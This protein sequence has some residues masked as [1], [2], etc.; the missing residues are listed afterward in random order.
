MA[1]S[2]TDFRGAFNGVRPNRFS[3]SGSFPQD[4]QSSIPFTRFDVYCKATQLPGSSIG[5]I[6]VPWMGRVTKFSGERTY[7]DW[8]IQVYDSSSSS[9]DLRSAFE[10]WIEY[11][12]GRDNHIIRY[13]QTAI[14]KVFF[15]DITNAVS[16]QGNPDASGAKKT[17]SLVNCFPVDIS[18]IDL[19]Y[20]LVDTFAEFTVTLAYDYWTFGE[21]Q[22]APTS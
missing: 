7:A 22:A 1:T 4:L 5:V 20:D 15:Q 19:S 2:I 6:P 12:D 9:E 8:T 21:V 11:M 16:T 17:V 10:L 14:W 13:N 3:I 18:P